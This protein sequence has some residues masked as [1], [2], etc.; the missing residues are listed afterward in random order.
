MQ[1]VVATAQPGLRNHWQWRPEWVS[2][3]PCLLWYLTFE[4]QPQL[5]RQAEQVHACLRD[6][7]TVDV[8]PLPWLHLTLDDVGFADELTP[9]QIE[10]VVGSARDAVQDWAPPPLTLGPLAPMDDSVV[11]RAGPTDELT[12]LR[13]RLRAATTTVLGHG[14]RSALDE[15]WPHVTLAYL[16]DVCA[17]ST[18]MDPLL[19]LAGARVVVAAPR[20]TLASVTR[21]DRHYQWTGRA[22]LPLTPPTT[23]SKS[24]RG[25]TPGHPMSE[26]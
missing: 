15:F 8:V 25:V 6:V 3:R 17:P 16:N 20:L 10:E 2:D 12:D 21:R 24:D 14:T 13:D 26:G 5:S 9:R 22:E 11:Q 18:V 1:H 19:P 23:E 4:S 7:P